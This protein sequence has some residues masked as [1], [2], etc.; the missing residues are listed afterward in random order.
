MSTIKKFLRSVQ[1]LFPFLHDTRFSFK[2]WMM[3]ITKFPHEDD[4]NA[5]KLFKP[6]VE[7]VFI[8][9]GSNRGEAILSMLIVSDFS[10]NVIG[11]EPN[12]LVFKKLE[13]YYNG[14]EKVMVHN[15]GLAN[16]NQEL[17]LFVPFYRK[18][19][20]DGLSSFKYESADNWLRT[21][22]WGFQEKNLNIKKVKCKVGRLDDFQLN[23]Y[24]I[25]I[26]VQGYELEVLKGSVDTLKANKPILLIESLNAETMDF[27]RT[28][29]YQFYYFTGGKLLAGRG[30]LNTFC[31]IEER[32]IELN[33]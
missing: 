32:Y 1:T 31:M 18:W 23:P 20:F 4:F 17:D 24:F 6:S 15:L 16:K 22:L 3:R 28:L 29:N 11:F 33:S 21:R 9:I 5:I 25:K 2:F 27:L 8:D 10:C 19:M 12:P 26:D 13:N 7:Q 30:K 14:N